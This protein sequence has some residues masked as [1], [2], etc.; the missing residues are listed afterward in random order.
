MRHNQHKALVLGTLLF[1][2]LFTLS[3]STFA[4]P[5]WWTWGN[6]GQSYSCAGGSGASCNSFANTIFSSNLPITTT[7]FSAQV[8]PYG[9]TFSPIFYDLNGDMYNE[10]VL[11]T[12][13]NVYVFDSSFNLQTFFTMT[14]SNVICGSGSVTH[15]SDTYAV[16]FISSNASGYYANSVYYDGI[17]Y[18]LKTPVLINATGKDCIVHSGTGFPTDDMIYTV[19]SNG[20]VSAT[21]LALGNTTVYVNGIAGMVE[22]TNGAGYPFFGGGTSTSGAVNNMYNL[23]YFMDDNTIAHTYYL[24]KFNPFTGVFTNVTIANFPNPVTHI[25]VEFGS[26]GNAKTN[27]VVLYIIYDD[28]TD[29]DRFYI[30]DANDMSSIISTTLTKKSGGTNEFFFPV[31]ADINLDANNEIC[32]Q[33]NTG[34]VGVQYFLKCYDITRTNFLNISFPTDLSNASIIKQGGFAYLFNDSK[35]QYIT[36]DYILKFNASTSLNYFINNT[37]Y[38][39]SSSTTPTIVNV[40]TVASSAAAKSVVF[41]SSIYQH[42]LL[43]EGTPGF[44]GNLICEYNETVFNCPNDCLIGAGTNGTAASGTVANFEYCDNSTWCLSD[45]CIQNQCIPIEGGQ[46]CVQDAQCRSNDCDVNHHCTDPGF[47][48][49]VKDF[50]SDAFGFGFF[51]QLLLGFLIIIIAGSIGALVGAAMGFVASISLGFFGTMIGLMLSVFVFAFIP[52][53][54]FVLLLFLI[55]GI[56]FLI[57]FYSGNG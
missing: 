2:L 53:W 52:V 30:R 19:N 42:I 20:S 28:D 15:A 11:T 13:N 49:L 41:S 26:L 27:P 7:N 32:T 44:C 33:D 43:A 10:E 56:V 4:N 47:V 34:A 9:T 24:M 51:D 14:G 37:N 22:R 1:F 23:Y 3:F 36:E 35:M 45:S 21:N 38:F 25:L 50:F 6:V 31:G 5:N 40:N 46:V 16:T 55:V 57:I 54:F 39:V 17:S 29:A 48:K 18:S 8:N 12:A